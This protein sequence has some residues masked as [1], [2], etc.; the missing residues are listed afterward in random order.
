[1]KGLKQKFQK[2]VVPRRLRICLAIPS[3]GFVRVE[4]LLSVVG[5]LGATRNADFFVD[6]KQSCYIEWNRTGLIQ[7]AIREKCEKVFFLDADMVV[8]ANAVNKLLALNKP[9]V[10]ADYHMRK[11]PITNNVKIADEQGNYIHVEPKDIPKV[12]FKCAA[13]PTGCMLVDVATVQKIPHPW[14]DLTYFPDGTLD[15]GEDVFFCR[16]LQEYGVEVWCDPTI[17]IGHIGTFTY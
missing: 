8:E 1:M 5:I 4:T 16:K 2:T 13:V 14:F 3:T 11:F 15:L 6:Q 9:I 10:G 17:E 12:P 7:T